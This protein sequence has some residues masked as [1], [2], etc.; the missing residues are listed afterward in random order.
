MS[1]MLTSKFGKKIL[2]KQNLGSKNYMKLNSNKYHLI[3]FGTK[4][5]H[6]RVRLG[7]FKFGKGIMFGKG[8][9][10]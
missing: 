1:V 9:T 6:V 10:N 4:Y 5:E 3:V 8:I 7:N 2:N